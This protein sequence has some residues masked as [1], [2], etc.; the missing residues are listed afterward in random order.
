MFHSLNAW[1][2][3]KGAEIVNGGALQFHDFVLVSNENAGFESKMIIGNPPRFDEARGPGIFNSLIV[4]HLDDNLYSPVTPRGLVLPFRSGF[5]VKD[6]DFWN[7]DQ[8][9]LYIKYV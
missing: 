6:V 4:S 9:S 8:V 5:L 1:N 7:F 3:F 2:C